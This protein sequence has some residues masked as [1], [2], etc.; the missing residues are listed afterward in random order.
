MNDDT[1]NI[2]FTNSDKV[3][4]IDKTDWHLVQ[5][6]KWSVIRSYTRRREVFYAVAQKRDGYKCT[7]I[8]MHRLIMDCPKGRIVD[9]LNH[10][11]LDNRRANMRICTYSQNN[12]NARA[13]TYD[14]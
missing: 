5:G 6:Y 10:D 14:T 12:L 9:H 7:T 11:G 3:C 1:F 8:L 2:T 4:V 13:R